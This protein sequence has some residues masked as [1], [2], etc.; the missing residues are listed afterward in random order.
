MILKLLQAKVEVIDMFPVF[1]QHKLTRHLFDFGHN[2]STEGATLTAQTIANYLKQTSV[3]KTKT[4]KFQSYEK[5]RKRQNRLYRVNFVVKDEKPY[6]PFNENASEICIF[7]NCNLQAF[8][9]E[10]AGI[11]ANLAYYLNEEIDYIG[12][13]LIFINNKEKFDKNAFE[14]CKKRDLAI[15]ISF[16][17]G[18]FVRSSCVG[19]KK[20]NAIKKFLTNRKNFYGKWSDTKL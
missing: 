8:H 16:L 2:I 10:G 3:F 7:G 14:E 5:L 13:K 18:S 11:A 6:V 19:G 20:I 1:M 15:C 9:N 17:S 4:S 12:R